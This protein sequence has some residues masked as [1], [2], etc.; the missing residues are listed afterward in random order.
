MDADNGRD[1]DDDSKEEV[2]MDDSSEDEEEQAGSGVGG[3]SND[4]GHVSRK[5]TSEYKGVSWYRG[6]NGRPWLALV[7]ING[8][9]KRLGPFRTEKE[10]RP[11]RLH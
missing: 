9:D 7:R 5:L 8:K 1:M 11:I 6:S 10:V 3:R 4:G 2:V